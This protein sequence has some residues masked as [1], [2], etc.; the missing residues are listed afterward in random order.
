MR[1][2]DELHAAFGDRARG[3]RL[4]LGA[5][6]VDDDDLRHV[7]LHRLDHHAV[8][9]LRP[10]DLHAARGADRR[11]RDVAIAGDLVRGVDDDHA[12]VHVVGQHAR[13]LAQHRRLADAGTA[14]QEHALV[15][16]DDLFDRG[17]RAEDG[18]ADAAGEADDAPAAVADAG[19]AVQRALDAGAVVFA[20][21]A[22]ARDHV[23]DVALG[24]L[25][26]AEHD[27]AVGEARLR[28]PAE[29]HDDLQQ[30]VL[31]WT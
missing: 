21:L 12:L 4:E 29:V 20:E 17:D 5:D 6:L 10:R 15:R 31:V 24:Y 22:D 3:L 30:L 26:L 16:L 27:L 1:R 13:H 2:A 9:L 18:A 7:V 28:Q 25:A 14:E 8:L 23:I 19:D 11:V